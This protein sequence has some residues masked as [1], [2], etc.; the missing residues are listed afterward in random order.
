MSADILDRRKSHPGTHTG[1]AFEQP[2]E[3][4]PLEGLRDG[5]QA[6]FQFPRD[7]APGHQIPEL[8]FSD[9]D[10]LQD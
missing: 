5:R 8:Q 9:L 4:E 1:P 7:R 6:H 10:P 2:F 3:L